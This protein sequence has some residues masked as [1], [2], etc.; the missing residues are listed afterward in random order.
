MNYSACA[1]V[2]GWILKIEAVFMA[3]S[4][5]VAA[6][7]GEKEGICFILSI[8]LCLAAGMLLTLKKPKNKVYYIRDGFITVAF[9]WILMSIMG[10][11]P[12]LLS[13]AIKSPVDALFETVS[14]FTTTGSSILT[15][16]ESLPRCV[17]FWRS[18]THW[19]GGM[20][21]LVFLLTLLPLAG[22][23]QMN[24][25][26]AESPGP[27]V[28]RLV[29]KV[30]S[31][32]KILYAIYIAMT[33]LQ[34]LLLLLGGM[35]LFDALTITF[36]TAGTGGFGI[37]NDSIASYSTYLQV[38]IT[39]FMI[40]FGVNFNIYFFILTKRFRQAFSSE[41]LK[42]Y[43]GIIGV[44]ILIITANIT[45]I[46]GNVATAFQQS[47]FQVASV[48]TTTGYAT[49]DF[50]LW[51]EVS[52]TI[53]VMLMMIGACAGSTA[54]G[55]KVS[56]IVILCKT[57]HKELL[58]FLHPR[59]IKKIKIDGKTVEHDVIRSTNVFLIL[60]IFI[61]AF[62]VLILALDNLDLVTNFT[63]VAA[64]LNNIGPGLGL[65]GPAS[66]FSVFSPLSTLVLT[67]D[68]LAG[69]LE[70]FPLLFLF[71]KDTWRKF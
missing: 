53:L 61:Y 58:Q 37:K 13:G 41:E 65:V 68:M 12:F 10:S 49:A 71:M 52:R 39:I 34:I 27:S 31:T 17:L 30:K 14:G 64:T 55:I 25:M 69:R 7:Y 70:L 11:L 59:S 6:I 33:I 38:V 4:L 3:P 35:P 19:I 21:I 50:N 9:S 28:S 23:S 62:S 43:F 1:Y 36:G 32:A 26:K 5:A 8:F 66:N 16:V 63:A 18:F 51:P 45:H 56:R 2:I 47:A 44:S 20:G 54:G 48:M 24:L 46:Y 22:G 60:Y 40:L 29:P 42:C 57:I 67:F 15:D